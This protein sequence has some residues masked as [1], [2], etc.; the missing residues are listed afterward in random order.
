MKKGFWILMLV[1][2]VAISV[3]IISSARAK[4]AMPP[5]EDVS[6]KE[7]SAFSPKEDALGKPAGKGSEQLKVSGPVWVEE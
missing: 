6:G 2:M 1:A 3:Y 5:R 7:A 4:Q